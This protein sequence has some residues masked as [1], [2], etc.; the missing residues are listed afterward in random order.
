MTVT[1]SHASLIVQGKDQAGIV[2]AVASVLTG[3]G[4]N[5]VSLDQYSDDPAGG[6]FF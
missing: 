1:R 6:D 5:I 3:F 4:A 2:A